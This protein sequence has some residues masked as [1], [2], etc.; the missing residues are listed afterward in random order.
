VSSGD[1]TI[2][3]WDL[4]S[5]ACVH[6]LRDLPDVPRSVR[7]VCDGRFV[8]SGGTTGA[9]RI[10]DPRTGRCLHTFDTGQGE[11][12]IAPTPDGRFALSSG[13]DATLRLWELD[14]DLAPSPT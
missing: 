8:M 14:W 3:L 2:R 7:F 1:R 5:G 13:G 9:I 12:R 6:V 11:V 10:W 4:A